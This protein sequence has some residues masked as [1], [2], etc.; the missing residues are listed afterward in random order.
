[1]KPI[2]TAWVA[3]LGMEYFESR[4]TATPNIIAAT[5]VES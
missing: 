4:N 2:A 1:M 5:T 3:E